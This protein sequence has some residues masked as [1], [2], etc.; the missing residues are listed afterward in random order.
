MHRVYS[1]ITTKKH[2]QARQVCLSRQHLVTIGKQP[3]EQRGRAPLAKLRLHPPNQIMLETLRA[4][5]QTIQ[6]HIP[7]SELVRLAGADLAWV[8]AAAADVRALKGSLIRLPFERERARAG[9]RPNA[10][11]VRGVPLTFRTRSMR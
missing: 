5:L 8:A 1:T 9:N 2:R 6:Q 10:G 7:S 4:T 11:T 3:V